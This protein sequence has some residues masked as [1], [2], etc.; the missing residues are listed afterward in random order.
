MGHPDLNDLAVFVRFVDHEGFAKAARELGVPTS[1]VSRTVQRLEQQ[2]GTRLLQRTTRSVRPTAEGRELYATV[3]GA[4]ETLKTAVS[5]LEPSFKRHRGKLRVT[6]PNDIGSTFL[7]DIVVAFADRHPLVHVDLV[8][9]NRTVNL[10]HEGFDMALRAG[11][12]VDSS[13]VARKLGDVA[14][15]LCASPAYL[16][17]HGAPATV[18]ELADHHAVMF[19]PAS[20]EPTWKLQGP[21]GE[22]SVAVRPRIVGDDFMF[23]RAAL[24]AGGGIGLVPRLVSAQDEVEGR[25][26]RVLP[27]WVLPS[28]ALHVVYPSGQNLPARVTAFRDFVVEAYADRIARC[29]KAAS[30]S[31]GPRRRHGLA[32][33]RN[34]GGASPRS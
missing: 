4:V 19:R 8:L 13:L 9:T 28:G 30:A 2:V 24:L 22:R 3:A 20:P 17:K 31:A 6:A 33:G 32:Q 25:L 34:G 11:R 1:T 16:E 23:V 10:V 29:E 12:L 26:V 21:G 14:S 7:A 18:E 27:D 5:S 15:V